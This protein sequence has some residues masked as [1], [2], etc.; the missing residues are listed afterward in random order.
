[1]IKVI[2]RT[3][4]RRNVLHCNYSIEQKVMLTD[5]VSCGNPTPPVPTELILVRHCLFC[6][7]WTFCRH[8]VNSPLFV[9]LYLCRFVP[10]KFNRRM[11]EIV[12]EIESLV[13]GIIKKRMKATES[14]TDDLLGLL[15]ESNSKEM[16]QNGSKSGM[17][18]EEVIEEC[19]LF[20]F[21]GQ[22]TTSSLLVWTMILLSKHEDWQDRAR[23]EVLQVFGKGKPDYQELNHL[24]IVSSKQICRCYSDFAH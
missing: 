15:L 22:E 19:K 6:C 18:I 7:G 10:T 5:F 9:L 14:I 21:A 23:D 12:R 4:L 2:S 24:K 13:L 20:Y 17:N 8:V 11:K 1:M 16:K 3:G